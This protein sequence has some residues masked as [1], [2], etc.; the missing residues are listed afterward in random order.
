MKCWIAI[1]QT[2]DYKKILNV[3]NDKNIDKNETEQNKD[4][5]N[6]K[7]TSV[8]Q[9]IPINFKRLFI[10]LLAKECLC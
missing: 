7:T 9:L 10:L 2:L 1:K 4:E 5:T 8:I 3:S 6:E